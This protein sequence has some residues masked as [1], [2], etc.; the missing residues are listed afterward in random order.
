MHILLGVILTGC[1]TT[2]KKATPQAIAPLRQA[3][4]T[5]QQKRIANFKQVTSSLA[6]KGVVLNL[7]E[8]TNKVKDSSLINL[9]KS[10]GIN[11]VYLRVNSLEDLNEDLTLFLAQAKEKNI[12]SEIYISLHETI[13][14][15]YRTTF[16]KLFS[17]E[18]LTFAQLVKTIDNY[19]SKNSNCV[20]L[21]IQL[22]P[23]N[24]T[25]SFITSKRAS[26]YMW[27]MENFGLNQDNDQLFNLALKAINE[28]KISSKIKVTVALE[29]FYHKYALEKKLSKSKISD[30]LSLRNNLV[31][32]M[33]ISTGNQPSQ[34]IK[35]SISNLNSLKKGNVVISLVL[36][37]HSNVTKGKFRHRDWND[38]VRSFTYFNRYLKRYPALKGFVIDSLPIMEHLLLESK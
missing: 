23:H 2:P 10:L 6:V 32:V 15:P 36:A 19:L 30:I 24:L 31:D 7:N 20:N 29:D 28:L 18:P 33:V 4:S 12:S 13:L 25:S 38:L 37:P 1:A 5:E 22:S 26:L 8:Y 11:K 3:S 16:D 27:S 21:T 34:V 35:Q 14:P 9:L 17:N